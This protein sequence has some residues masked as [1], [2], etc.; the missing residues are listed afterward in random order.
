MPWEG[1]DRLDLSGFARPEFAVAEGKGV[2]TLTTAKL[3][4]AVALCAAR[5]LGSAQVKA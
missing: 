3:S 5:Q 2:I 1:R 4:L